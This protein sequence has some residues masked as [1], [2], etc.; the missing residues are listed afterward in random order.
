M[1]EI[2]RSTQ[3]EGAAKLMV[4]KGVVFTAHP[5]VKRDF[6]KDVTLFECLRVRVIES[7]AEMGDDHKEGRR[8][9]PNPAPPW[10]H[11]LPLRERPHLA[12]PPVAGVG[13]RHARGEVLLCRDANGTKGRI[14]QGHGPDQL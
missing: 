11:A 9:R 14:L 2:E 3:E 7:L 6:G 5:A 10:Y 4:L 8:G 12:S 13:Q 1:D